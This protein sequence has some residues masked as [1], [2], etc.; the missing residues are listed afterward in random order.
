MTWFRLE[1]QTSLRKECFVLLYQLMRGTPLGNN[2]TIF[3]DD[4]I[5]KVLLFFQSGPL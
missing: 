1:K 4:L 5:A 3:K 2:K